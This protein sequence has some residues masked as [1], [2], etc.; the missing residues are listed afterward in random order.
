MGASVP[1]RVL[2]NHDLSKMVDTSDE[3]IQT[4]TGIHERRIAEDGEPASEYAFK[5]A[6]IAMEDSGLLPEELDVIIVGTV[7]PDMTFP[8]TACFLQ[9][10]LGAKNAAAFDISAA[11][12][13]FIYGLDL[14]D[15][16]IA[17]EKHK[18]ILV[19]GVELLS[20]ITNWEDRATCVLF[21]DGAGAVVMQPTNR[22]RGIV[23]TYIKSDGNLHE[24]LNMQ[25]GGSI[26]PSQK[27]SD[28]P[29][30]FYIKM[31]GR[32]VF[33]HAVSCMGE[34]ATKI[35]EENGFSTEEINLIIPHQANI[36]IIDAIA[37]RLSVPRDKVYIN[38]DRF[39]NTSAASIPIAMY[40]AYKNGQITEN[41]LVLLVAFGGGFT[42]GSA[43]IKF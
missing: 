16:M 26:Y 31:E 12:S 32:E 24:L 6:Q 7:T 29:D 34:A 18:N 17:S 3:W 40:E 35:I 43:L 38:V 39:G 22:D 5:A 36:R 21:G 37:K 14:A 15:G 9:D 11:C 8:S 23:N 30:K 42:W 13:G 20:R 4:R 33:R 10:K 41:S 2:T 25:G 1:E 27:V 28:F 19:V